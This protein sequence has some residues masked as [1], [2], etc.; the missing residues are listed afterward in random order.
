MFDFKSETGP[1]VFYPLK[2]MLS[3]V[4]A[5]PTFF[6]GMENHGEGSMKNEIRSIL[7]V[8]KRPAS[9]SFLPFPEKM[10]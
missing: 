9:S 1:P 6:A 2:K 5:I 3:D 4:F 10:P 7:P 8:W